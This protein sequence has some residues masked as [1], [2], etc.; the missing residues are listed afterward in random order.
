MV[1]DF[2][3]NGGSLGGSMLRRKKWPFELLR[4]VPA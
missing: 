2:Y 4:D 3:L 1:A